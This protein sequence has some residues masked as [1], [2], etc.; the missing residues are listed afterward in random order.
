[1]AR[2]VPEGVCV[3]RHQN[4]IAVGNKSCVYVRAS[5]GRRTGEFGLFFKCY[6]WCYFAFDSFVGAAVASACVL[7]LV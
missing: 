3:C 4:W 5:F 7:K 6:A 2:E 1:M